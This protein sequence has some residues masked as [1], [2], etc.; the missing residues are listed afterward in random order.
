M[1]GTNSFPAHIPDA[2][3][4][5]PL[6]VDDSGTQAAI[7]AL[8]ATIDNGVDVSIVAPAPLLVDSAQKPKIFAGVFYVVSSGSA[9]ETL[10]NA[11]G[12]TH[13]TDSFDESTLIS[14]AG[15]SSVESLTITSFDADPN[16]DGSTGKFVYAEMVGGARVYLPTGMS[17]S[18]SQLETFAT[19]SLT[20]INKLGVQGEAH[21]IVNYT[22]RG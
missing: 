16:I 7:A 17:L 12:I 21:A 22:V 20:G 6:P 4:A 1:S 15:G 2:P 18:W 3:L 19:A 9:K 11:S 14:L 10:L 8:T 13:V 5:N